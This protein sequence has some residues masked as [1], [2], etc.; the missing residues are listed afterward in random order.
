[1]CELRE[2]VRADV[3]TVS[4]H[5][6]VLREA[7]VVGSEKRGANVYY[8][9]RMECVRGFLACV[10]RFNARRVEE[11]ACVLCG[12][13]GPEFRSQKPGDSVSSS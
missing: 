11:H 1:M 3:S 8:P 9:L 10:D 2:L 12:R 5:L 13:N 6:S 7:G 4:K